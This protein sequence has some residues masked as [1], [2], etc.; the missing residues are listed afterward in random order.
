MNGVCGDTVK[1]IVEQDEDFQK[2]VEQKKAENTQDILSYMESKR[3]TVCE[4]I[5]KGLDVLN[6]SEKLAEASPAQITTAIG[7]LI[8]K[9]AMVTGAVGTAAEEDGLSRSLRELAE[10]LE[11]DD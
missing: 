1:R 3:Q 9:W 5:T 6:D 8:D 11:S 4:I 2:K 7:T 10:G